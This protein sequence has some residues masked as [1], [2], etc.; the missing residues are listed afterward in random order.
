MKVFDATLTTLERS[1][2]ARVDR[3]NALAGDV[4][5]VATAGYIPVDIDVEARLSQTNFSAAGQLAPVATVEGQI[6]VAAPPGPALA[7]ETVGPLA[8]PG[9]DG[10]RVDLDRTLAALA[11]N[12][13]QYGAAAKAAAKKLAILS[14]VANDGS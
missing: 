6:P 5:N 9:L 3:Q 7:G 10:N 1:L 4:A 11:E 8:A 12:A 2:D 13:L 14:Y